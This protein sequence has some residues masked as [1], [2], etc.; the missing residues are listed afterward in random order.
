MIQFIIDTSIAAM[1]ITV[2][3]VVLYII[4]DVAIDQYKNM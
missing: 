3:A 1:A 4:I 2:I